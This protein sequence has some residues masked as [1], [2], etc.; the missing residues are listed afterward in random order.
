VKELNIASPSSARL[1]CDNLGAMYLLANLV[2]LARTKHIQI[3]YYHFVRER[4]ESKLFEI[5]FIYTGDQL[6]DGFTKPLS[7]R[8]LVQ[9]RCNLKL[10]K[11]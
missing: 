7:T 6:V 4:L 11:V 3:F 5:R 10:D 9:L 1:W 2:F 8:Q